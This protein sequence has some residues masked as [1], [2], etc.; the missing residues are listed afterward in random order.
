VYNVESKINEF[1]IFLKENHIRS[2]EANKYKYQAGIIYSDLFNEAEKM[3]DYI[4]N[5]SEAIAEIE[6]PVK[7]KSYP[8]GK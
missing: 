3:G 5:V 7:H 2:I 4:I 6:K 8:T 1:R